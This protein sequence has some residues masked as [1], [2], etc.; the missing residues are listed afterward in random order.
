MRHIQ[1][2]SEVGSLQQSLRRPQIGDKHFK[3][4][5]RRLM[6]RVL[7][8]EF[9]S[10]S[11]SLAWDADV[12]ANDI[13]AQTRNTPHLLLNDTYSHQYRSVQCSSCGECGES[14]YIS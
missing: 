12:D 5:T 6:D 7:Y 1:L 4:R 2:I 10:P 13:L 14:Y 8:P 9:V 11:E 3:Y